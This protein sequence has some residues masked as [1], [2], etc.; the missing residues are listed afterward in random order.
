MTLALPVLWL[1]ALWSDGRRHRSNF[2]QY[3]GMLVAIGAFFAGDLAVWHWS[4]ILTSVANAT[5][6]ANLAPIVVTAVAWAVYAERPR[7]VFLAGLVTAL[8]GTAL[9]IGANFGHGGSALA[10]DGLGLITAM[11]YAGYQM[12]VTRL[13]A[14]VSTASLMAWSSSVM[15]LLLLPVAWLSGDT[16]LPH[17][18]Y[19]WGL[20]LG[21]ALIA[22]AAGQSL[23]AYAMAH[24]PGVF[25]SVGLLLQPVMAALFAWLLLGEVLGPL[26]FA[27]GLLVLSGIALARRATA[28][29]GAR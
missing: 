6:L 1:W 7:P 24:L 27:G 14:A 4:I 18:V 17:S 16:L 9:L 2:M 19:G 22:Q 5:L 28:K 23:I 21:L 12:T 3:R 15:A 29:S 10:G 25:S 8:C 13:R 20:L 26:Q 11:F